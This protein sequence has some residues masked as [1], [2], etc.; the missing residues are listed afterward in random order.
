MYGHGLRIQSFQAQEGI[1]MPI[2][3]LGSSIQKRHLDFA[4]E[5]IECTPNAIVESLSM[6]PTKYFT[7]HE[8]K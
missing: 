8:Y 2:I 7:C 3:G 1:S 6:L 4:T 5:F